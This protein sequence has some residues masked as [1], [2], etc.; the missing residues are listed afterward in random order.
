MCAGF[1]VEGFPS[2]ISGRFTRLVV[3]G[4]IDGAINAGP[5]TAVRAP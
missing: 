4:D 5:N 2:L 3:G 1:Q